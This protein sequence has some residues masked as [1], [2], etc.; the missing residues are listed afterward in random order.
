MAV[1]LYKYNI[2]SWY[3]QEISTWV[4]QLFT[5]LAVL[6]MPNMRKS[7][8]NAITFALFK[9]QDLHLETVLPTLGLSC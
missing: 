8:V 2:P 4:F 9:L 5:I 6:I 1:I 3:W 7:N